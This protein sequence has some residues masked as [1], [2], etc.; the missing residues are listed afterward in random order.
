[1]VGVVEATVGGAL[2]DTDVEVGDG[3]VVAGDGEVGAA[4]VVWVV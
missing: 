1:V 2:G 4:V 3:V